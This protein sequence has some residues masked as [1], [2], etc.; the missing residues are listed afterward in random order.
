MNAGSDDPVGDLISLALAEDLGVSGDITTEAFITA[1]SISRAT[2]VARED[3]VASGLATAQEVFLRVDSSLEVSVLCCEGETLQA[4]SVLLEV[5]G[6]TRSILSAERTILNFLGRLCGIATLSR[7]YADEIRGMDVQL[8]DTRKTTPGWRKLEK[9]AVKAGGGV[10]HRMGLYDAVL[11]KDNHLAAIGDLSALPPVIAKLRTEHPGLPIEIEADTLEQVETLLA[12]ASI[13][14]ILLDNMSPEMMRKAVALRAA[15]A[16]R[17]QLEA[18]GGVTFETLR[19]IAGTGVDRISI[20]ALT[21][22]TV[23]TDLSLELYH[24]D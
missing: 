16:P 5:T 9:Q 3:C 7:R 18:S 21:H 4:G 17:V 19:R 14:V 13:N 2:V 10:N 24:A 20:G 23:S 8:L 15:K 1:D 11:V 12:T 6:S 22:S